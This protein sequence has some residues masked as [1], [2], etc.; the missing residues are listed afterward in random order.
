MGFEDH[1]AIDVSWYGAQ[2][3][4][5][6]IGGRLL[7]EAEW[8]YAA[9]GPEN[10]VYPWG[11]MYDCSLGN[12][13]DWAEANAGSFSAAPG[14]DG[15]DFTSPVDAFPEGASWLGAQDLAGNVW[16]WVADWRAPY[17]ATLQVNP[18][19]PDAG[20]HKVV[21]GGSWDDYAWGVRTT[22][23]WEYDPN[24]RSASIGFRCAYPAVP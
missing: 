7:T 22:L 17:P 10:R 23:R 9:S 14:C 19:G 21:R 8:E 5:E 15:Y 16:D 24:E 20:T 3:Y 13:K 18:T 1:P 4:C 2:A 12:F 11:D 6:W